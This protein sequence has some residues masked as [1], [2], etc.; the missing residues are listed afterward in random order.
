MNMF[1]LMAL[2]VIFSPVILLY[3][4]LTGDRDMPPRDRLFA[5]KEKRKP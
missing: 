4:I 5:T 3:R 1:I 2:L